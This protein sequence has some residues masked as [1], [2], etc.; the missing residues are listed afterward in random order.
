MKDTSYKP[1]LFLPEHG[2]WVVVGNETRQ[3]L[4][5]ES[6]GFVREMTTN[7]LNEYAFIQED[8]QWVRETEHLQRHQIITAYLARRGER[9]TSSTVLC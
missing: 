2:V 7:E 5:M 9:L 4:V 1:V 6:D 8:Y 3:T